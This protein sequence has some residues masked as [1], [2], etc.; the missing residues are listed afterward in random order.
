MA[1]KIKMKVLHFELE[2]CLFIK[3][4]MKLRLSRLRQGG[5]NI[6][7]GRAEKRQVR[8]ALSGEPPLPP[9]SLSLSFL[10]CCIWPDQ[11][12]PSSLIHSLSSSRQH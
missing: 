10:L 2:S 5:R 1:V 11:K 4:F 6:T 12:L 9:V 7:G 3:F 8:E